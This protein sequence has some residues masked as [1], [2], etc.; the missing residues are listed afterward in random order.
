M[1]RTTTTE[2]WRQDKVL[3]AADAVKKAEKRLLVCEQFRRQAADVEREAD[4][5]CGE[6]R[7]DV[8]NAWAALRELLQPQPEFGPAFDKAAVTVRDCEEHK[9]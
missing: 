1:H 4:R 6:A 2:D 7:D 5:A 9:A 3:R 8:Q